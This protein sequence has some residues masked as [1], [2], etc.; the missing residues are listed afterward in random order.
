MSIEHAIQKSFTKNCT[1]GNR[2]EQSVVL[3]ARWTVPGHL[4]DTALE[5]MMPASVSYWFSKLIQ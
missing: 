4:L 5:D 1:I 2:R 3:E